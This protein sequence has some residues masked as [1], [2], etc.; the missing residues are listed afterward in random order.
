[1][2]VIAT[3]LL[4]WLAE[5]ALRS[6]AVACVALLVVAMIPRKRA[7]LRL[8]VWTGVLYVALAM[9]L[10]SLFLP[11][12]KVAIPA[13]AWPVTRNAAPALAATAQASPS[14]PRISGGS[15]LNQP[16]RAVQAKATQEGGLASVSPIASEPGTQAATSVPSPGTP[17]RSVSWEAIALGF[18]LLGFI[19]LLARLLLGI[20]GS[21]RLA[22]TA[23]DVC[24]RFFPRKGEAE[25]THISLA[26]E[27]L[28]S[29]SHHAGLKVPPRLKQ[30]AALLVP[31][32]VGILKPVILLP[33]G[34]RE[35]PEPEL[36]AVLAHE[37]SHVCR[38]DA[39]TQLLSLL[40]RAIFWFSP[41]GWWLHCQLTDLAEQAS[42]EAALA[43]GA[44]RKLYAKTLLGFF[45]R[46]ESVPGR[47]RWQALSMAD[48][49]GSGNAERRV[50]RIL[51]WQRGTAMKK[52]FVILL[53]AV[54]APVILLAASLHPL[55]SYAQPETSLQPSTPP[56]AAVAL[57]SEARDA[58]SSPQLRA[59]REDVADA[60]KDARSANTS[61]MLTSRE[62]QSAQDAVANA[63]K[64][65]GAAEQ[66]NRSAN[67]INIEGGSFNIG[68]GPRYVMMKANSESVDMSGDN[69]D[70]Q[71]AR[72]LREKIKGDFI[73]FERDEKSY[74][75][76]DP[77]F[78]ARV[79][80]LFAPQEELSKQQDA[81]G[82]Q[83]DE[84]GRQQDALGAQMDKV[85]V[86]V[87]DI[88]P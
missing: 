2:K 84:L 11:R 7:A 21:R 73:W 44:D 19:T 68:S 50:E 6:L 67:T 23:E 52:S 77:A 32:T 46:L 33:A 27:L 75:I 54:A 78:L 36:Q 49:S 38:R 60:Q 43:G 88:R 35:W 57:S 64:A 70:L 48:L 69:E 61:V 13:S 5:P 30:S 9:P 4:A 71:H 66:S 76:T 85:K 8:Y 79:S 10:L 1:M 39:L 81:L 41:L 74:V 3:D 63:Q 17:A 53:V 12:L 72:K 59:E 86:K 28:F 25:D 18:Y 29:Q 34:W 22:R 37:I 87:P 80:A 58:G 83:Q 65:A 42:D 14:G 31:A 24:P 20:R 82:K 45:A 55:V 26:L 15:V 16:H 62:V 47:V 56:Q 51:A 40:H